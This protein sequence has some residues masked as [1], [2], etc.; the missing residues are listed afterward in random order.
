MKR[1]L[2]ALAL[3]CVLSGSAFAGDIH[4]CGDAAPAPTQSSS[5]TT[6]VI[7]TIISLVV[8]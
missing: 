3:T 1:Y 8:G 6:T 2:I 5:V 4:T 7:L